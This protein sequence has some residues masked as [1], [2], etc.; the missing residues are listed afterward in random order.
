[1]GIPIANPYGGLAGLGQ[2]TAAQAAD[3][4]MPQSTIS[5]TAG[6]TQTVWNDI[7]QAA[8]S[9]QF[10]GF[11]QSGCT[12]VSAGG[13]IKIIQQGAGLALTGTSMGLTAAG[14]VASATLAPFTLGISA[15]IGLFPLFFAHHSAAVAK[16]QK[17]VCASVPAANNYLQQIEAAVS[18]GIQTPAQGI[19][20]LQSLLQDFTSNVSSIMK[21]SASSCN[22]AC[23]WVKELTAIVAYQ[24]AQ[25]QEQATAA[26][27]SP[28]SAVTSLVPASISAPV[29]SAVSSV[30]AA[31]TLPTWAIWLLGGLVV[32]SLL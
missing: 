18:S 31:T 29:T 14:V 1:M 4:A 7:E 21:N 8:A 9:G 22:A 19:A 12:G 28:A 15:L 16:E 13:N 11:N 20:A 10:V 30:A 27:A 2:I 32:W 24:T 5:S 26:A 17:I 25:Y 6:F 3:Q 23:V